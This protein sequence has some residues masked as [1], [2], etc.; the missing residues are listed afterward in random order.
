MVFA[1]SGI[2]KVLWGSLPSERLFH[3]EKRKI[4]SSQHTLSGLII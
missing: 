3:D 2:A 4:N 1:Y